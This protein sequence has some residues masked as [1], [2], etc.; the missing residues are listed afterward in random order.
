MG[1]DAPHY[2]R[3][4]T[5]IYLVARGTVTARVEGETIALRAGDMLA[6]APG[7]AHTFL[8]SSDDYLHFVIHIPALPDSEAHA[9]HVGVARNRLGL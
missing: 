9:D 5:E 2:H 7:E 8:A 1:I 3:R 6:F 4:M